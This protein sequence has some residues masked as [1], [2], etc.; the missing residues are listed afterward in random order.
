MTDEKNAF[1]GLSTD[2]VPTLEV[3]RAFS[4]PE[5]APSVAL[6]EFSFDCGTVYVVVNEEDD[7]L[8][9]TRARPESHYVPVE[10]RADSLLGKSLFDAR[11]MTNI[12]GY[13]DCLQ[14]ELRESTAPNALSYVQMTAIASRIKLE[15][16]LP[17]D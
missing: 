8:L 11:I 6:F 12:R 1:A 10:F 9:S 17:S 5:T 13:E 14:L 7:T 2:Q 3:I 4:K 16:L 15:V